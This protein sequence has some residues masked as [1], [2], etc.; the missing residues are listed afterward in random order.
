MRNLLLLAVGVAIGYFVGYSDARKHPKHVVERM[1]DK[2][3]VGARKNLDNNAD[4]RYE[5]LNR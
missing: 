4:R 2:V 5:G 1:L 3:G